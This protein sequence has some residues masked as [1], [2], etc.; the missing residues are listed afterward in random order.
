MI[1][2]HRSEKKYKSTFADAK[3]S[4]IDVSS[5]LCCIIDGSGATDY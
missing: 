2:Y 5:Y 1:E 3:I 4:L